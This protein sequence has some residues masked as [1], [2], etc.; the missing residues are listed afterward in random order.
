PAWL[1]LAASLAALAAVTAAGVAGAFLLNEVGPKPSVVPVVSPAASPSPAPTAGV[2]P[3]PTTDPLASIPS[4]QFAGLL[5]ASHGWVV[6]RDTFLATADR[7]ATWT[8]TPLPGPRVGSGVLGATFADADHGWLATLDSDDL[9]RRVFDVWRTTDGGRSWQKAVLH[10]GAVA[11]ETMGNAHFSVVGPGHL[12]VWIEGGMPSGWTSDLYEST[13]GGVTWSNPRISAE[14]V[15]GPTAFADALHGV[16]AGGAPGYRLYR[17]SDGGT[18]WSPVTYPLPKGADR[19]LTTFLGAPRFLD[20]RHG[21]ITALSS[22]PDLLPMLVIL[23]TA[24]AGA[25]WSLATV[26]ADHQGPVAFVTATDW[27]EI[28]GTSV[29][30]TTDGGATW[31]ERS[32]NGMPG[33]AAGLSMPNRTDGWATVEPLGCGSS[34]CIARQLVATSDGWRTARTL[35][36]PSRT[37]AAAPSP[38]PSS[39]SPSGA[40]DGPSAADVAAAARAVDRYTGDLVAGDYAT[41]WSYLAPEARTR[42]GSLASF[43]DERRAF[44]ASVRGKYFVTPQPTDVAPISD[45]IA[46][47]GPRIDVASAVLV[48]VA[49]PA[50]AGNNAGWELYVVAP[51]TGPDGVVIYPVR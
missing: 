44:F 33:I 26:D 3:R 25:T 45:W 18:S 28:A 8:Q 16:V 31:S 11:S 47:T 27:V 36:L 5:D 38:S 12:L 37:A 9:S 2:S 17:T 32:I 24:D 14:G 7:G 21:A 1:L 48:E 51:G 15:S 30:E 4:I 41:A 43:T 10:E 34:P 20:S 49:Y 19:T 40:A 22:T 35:T 46:G 6:G 42:R 13:D 23:S 50:L 29:R 39:P